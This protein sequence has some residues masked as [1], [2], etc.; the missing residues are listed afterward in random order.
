MKISLCIDSFNSIKI[1]GSRLKSSSSISFNLF[2]GTRF[3]IMS[4]ESE[5]CNYFKFLFKKLVSFSLIFLLKRLINSLLNSK[6]TFL[7]DIFF[8]KLIK[9]F[10]LLNLKLFS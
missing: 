2:S 7:S 1:S 8:V 10:H 5:G 9:M 3:S 6:F 4:A